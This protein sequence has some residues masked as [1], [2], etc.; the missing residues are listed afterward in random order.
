M[1]SE[2]RKRLGRYL[3]DGGI[4]GAVQPEKQVKEPRKMTE[5]RGENQEWGH[6]EIKGRR[7]EGA[8]HPREVTYAGD[9][10]GQWLSWQGSR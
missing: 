7:R 4:Q 8:N 5:R 6:A 9:R 2:E 3:G 10:R 1:G